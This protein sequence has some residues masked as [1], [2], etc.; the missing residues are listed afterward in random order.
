MGELQ[1]NSWSD[2]AQLC[3]LG[4]GSGLQFPFHFSLCLKEHVTDLNC[5]VA[6]LHWGALPWYLRLS[7]SFTSY[8]FCQSTL[9]TASLCAWPLKLTET[10]QLCFEVLLIKKKNSNHQSV[11]KAISE[12]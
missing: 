9:N 1:A 3:R 6:L 4:G 12:Q 2:G 10:Y 7:K 5:F 8:R 11:S